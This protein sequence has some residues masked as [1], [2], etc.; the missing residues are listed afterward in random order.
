VFSRSFAHSKAV[1]FQTF[2]I[3]SWVH[4]TKPPGE[5]LRHQRTLG[6]WTRLRVCPSLQRIPNKS[7]GQ[8]EILF[9]LFLLP[10]TLPPLS[11]ILD[12]DHSKYIPTH[13]T[14]L[15]PSTSINMDAA[16]NLA[17]SAATSAQNA[18]NYVADS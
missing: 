5:N 11:R 15:K 12:F 18:A 6:A 16:K 4:V 14:T 13:S 10:S 17:N 9:F 1:G 7:Q 8:V 2:P 3:F